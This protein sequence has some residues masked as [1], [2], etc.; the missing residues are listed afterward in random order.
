MNFCFPHIADAFVSAKNPVTIRVKRRKKYWERVNSAGK[1]KVDFLIY[2]TNLHVQYSLS[3]KAFLTIFFLKPCQFA[4]KSFFLSYTTRICICT[5]SLFYNAF[6]RIFF[7]IFL[8][9]LVQKFNVPH[10]ADEFAITIF[11]INKGLSADFP[12]KFLPNFC[13]FYSTQLP[14]Q[15][16]ST[17]SPQHPDLTRHSGLQSVWQL[18]QGTLSIPA[19]KSP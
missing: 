10:I 9:F 16:L 5:F 1:S 17:H 18:V 6:L 7:Q 8:L 3:F 19:W 11:R 4:L 15:P 12:E 14:W 13:I 2:W